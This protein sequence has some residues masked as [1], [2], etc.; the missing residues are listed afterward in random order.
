PFL[1]RHLH[2]RD[3]YLKQG[4]LYRNPKLR[5][6][7]LFP[8]FLRSRLLF[9]IEPLRETFLRRKKFTNHL[10]CVYHILFQTRPDTIEEKENILLKIFH[11][12]YQ[13][14]V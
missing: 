5:G 2:A 3:T 1:R 9:N 7:P 11:L 10:C 12:F 8:K 4:F 6:L 13:Q 14:S